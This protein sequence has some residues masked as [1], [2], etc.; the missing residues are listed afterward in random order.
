MIISLK[1]TISATEIRGNHTFVVMDVSGVGYKIYV[2]PS[3]LPSFDLGK[4]RLIW[5][6]LAV[7][8][9]SQEL[10]GFLDKESLDF[11]ELLISISGI[12]PKG[13]LAILAV[14]PLET[15]KKAIS[16]GDTTYM[17][18][19]SGIGKKTA[20]KVVLELKDKLAILGDTLDESLRGD[21]DVL[22]ALKALGYSHN[23]ARDAVK[24]I[25]DEIIGVNE[26][27]KAALK[28][29]GEK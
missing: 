7:R 22:E 14:A 4:E 23:E 20:E 26:R 28:N 12:G 21:V 8:E 19:V 11:F 24:N 6:H 5:T 29:I 2:S 13:A 15:L 17:T 16:S 1:G 9:N 25:S 18:K 27:I 3:D 10:F